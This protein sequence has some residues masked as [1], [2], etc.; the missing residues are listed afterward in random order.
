MRSIVQNQHKN[1]QL[2]VRTAHSKTTQGKFPLTLSSL[3]NN[4]PAEAW[5]ILV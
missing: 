4:I 2:D 3:Q 1:K 5:N